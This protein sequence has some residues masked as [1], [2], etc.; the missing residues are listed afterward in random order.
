M[1][2]G[3]S[4]VVASVAPKAVQDAMDAELARASRW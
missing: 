4:P 2:A 3:A 1:P